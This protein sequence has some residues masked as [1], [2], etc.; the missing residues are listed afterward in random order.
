V[1]ASKTAGIR[2]NVRN[3]G[4]CRQTLLRRREI[5]KKPDPRISPSLKLHIPKTRSKAGRLGIAKN[6]LIFCSSTMS[7]VYVPQHMQAMG[8]DSDVALLRKE[9]RPSAGSSKC[10]RCSSAEPV[11]L[12]VRAWGKYT[13]SFRKQPA[14]SGQ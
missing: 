11:F 2:Q 8:K 9:V 10:E 4:K 13:C 6:S 14:K 1:P 7:L 5:Q 12:T 3:W